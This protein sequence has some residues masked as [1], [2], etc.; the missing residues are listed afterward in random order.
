MY[1]YALYM[2]IYVLCCSSTV[3]ITLCLSL[4]SLGTRSPAMAWY[5]GLLG[6]I[7]SNNNIIVLIVHYV[8]SIEI[9]ICP[10]DY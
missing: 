7:L 10:D 5:P 8:T 6:Q 3:F 2:Y 4:P 1:M 9:I